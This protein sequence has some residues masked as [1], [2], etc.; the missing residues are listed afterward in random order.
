MHKKTIGTFF[1]CVFLSVFSFGQEDIYYNSS[2]SISN[3]VSCDRVH[4][5]SKSRNA[6]SKRSF[7]AAEPYFLRSY[8]SQEDFAALQLGKRK[9]SKVFL[10][11]KVFKFNTC[12]KDDES[13]EL[14]LENG[15]T[16]SIRNKLNVNCNGDLVVELDRKDVEQLLEQSITSFMVLSF[17]KDFEFHLSSDIA[18]KFRE[19]LK[20]LSDYNF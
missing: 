6:L 8:N 17:Q 19:D 20:C 15:L 16:Y 12:I 7:A 5:E 4:V 11:I 10:Y 13:L 18:T 2:D 1:L 3:K 9:G 14:I